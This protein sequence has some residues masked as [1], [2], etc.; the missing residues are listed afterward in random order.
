MSA[1]TVEMQDTEESRGEAPS[2]AEGGGGTVPEG[3]QEEV[4]YK[5]GQ[6]APGRGGG[7][8]GGRGES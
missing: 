3:F 7:L 8:N 1:V 5:L 2:T 6:R 4:T